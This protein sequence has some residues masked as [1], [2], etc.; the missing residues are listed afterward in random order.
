MAQKQYNSPMEMYSEEALEEIRTE[1]T[2]GLVIIYPASAVISIWSVWLVLSLK[3]MKSFIIFSGIP[4]N[5]SNA[6][7]PTG[8]DFDTSQSSVLSFILGNDSMSLESNKKVVI[9]DAGEWMF[10]EFIVHST[11]YCN[12]IYIFNCQYHFM[13][14]Q[15]L[16]QYVHFGQKSL[17]K[18]VDTKHTSLLHRIH[19]YIT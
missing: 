11:Y 4:F 16:I 7:N 12:P 5:A 17:Y 14:V 8:K 13:N 2:L 19:Y 3:F 1:G 9:S 6:M 10:L 18:F 15:M